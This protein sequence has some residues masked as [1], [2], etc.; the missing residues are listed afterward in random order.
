MNKVKAISNV[1][2]M[3]AEGIIS[4]NEAAKMVNAIEGVVLMN[5]KRQGAMRAYIVTIDGTQ[6]QVNF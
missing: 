6:T 5:Y 2:K 3:Y 4:M 1:G